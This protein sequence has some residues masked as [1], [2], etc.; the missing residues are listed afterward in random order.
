MTV[1]GPQEWPCF[2][3]EEMAVCVPEFQNTFE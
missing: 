2:L 1:G 3:F